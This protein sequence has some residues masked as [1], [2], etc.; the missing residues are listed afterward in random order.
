MRGTSS[1]AAG[2]LPHA[3]RLVIIARDPLCR[4]A[5]LVAYIMHTMRITT[6]GRR[7]FHDKRIRERSGSYP[8]AMSS[9]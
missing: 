5:H 1:L 2:I 8:S 7:R 4:N 6:V 3:Q 9:L